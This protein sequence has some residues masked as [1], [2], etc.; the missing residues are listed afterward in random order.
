MVIL[1]N[2]AKYYTK[3]W[4]YFIDGN[5]GKNKSKISPATGDE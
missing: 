4:F 2:G 5:P 1:T 3:E